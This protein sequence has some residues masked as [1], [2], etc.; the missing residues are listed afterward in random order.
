ME[1]CFYIKKS[2]LKEKIKIDEKNTVGKKLSER[3][4]RVK[5]IIFGEKKE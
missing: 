1:S 5:N 3:K 4:D 2:L